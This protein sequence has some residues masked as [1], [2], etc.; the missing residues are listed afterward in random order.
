ME[1]SVGIVI[2][3]YRP[4]LDR[5]VEYVFDLEEALDPEGIRIELDAPETYAMGRLGTVPAVVNAAPYRRGKG[6]AI[7][8]GFEALE[9]DILAFV[10]ADGSTPASELGR[11]IDAIDEENSPIAVGSRRH[12]QSRVRAHQTR[13]RRL[14]GDVFPWLARQVLDVSLADFQC[15]AKAMTAPAWN[16]VK[17]HIYAAGFAWDV[18]M[19][20]VARALD[21]PLA[22]VPIEW[23]DRPGSTVSPLRTPVELL[24]GLWTARRRA[25]SLAGTGRDETAASDVRQ[26]L[27]TER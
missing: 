15:G 17:G 6:A 11:I 1:A 25:N 21:I 14:L 19:I 24:Y 26:R 22:E 4:N 27:D 23:E 7:T 10:D 12:P 9:T 18:E 8:A 20:A 13:G 16:E 5:L 3:A 2:P